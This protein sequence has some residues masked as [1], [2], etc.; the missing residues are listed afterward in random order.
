MEIKPNQ[1]VTTAQR[2][3]LADNG[4]PGMDGREGLG[5]TTETHQGQIAAAIY[6]NAAHLDNRQLD[7]IVEWVRLYRN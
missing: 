4:T 7:D 1:F 3:V 5:S 6:A 2:R